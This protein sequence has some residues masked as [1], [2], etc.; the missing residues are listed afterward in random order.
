MRHAAQEGRAN[1]ARAKEEEAHKRFALDELP[2]VG[3]AAGEVDY[4]ADLYSSS[5]DEDEE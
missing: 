2:E 1:Q 3:T 5:D 4:T